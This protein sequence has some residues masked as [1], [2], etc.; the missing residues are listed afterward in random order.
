MSS[1]IIQNVAYDNY[2]NFQHVNVIFSQYI[3]SLFRGLFNDE[4]DSPN[5]DTFGAF[6]S[7]KSF[8]WV[9]LDFYFLVGKW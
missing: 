7:Q 3:I 2:H 6:F 8:M 4:T 5:F 9:S 1:E